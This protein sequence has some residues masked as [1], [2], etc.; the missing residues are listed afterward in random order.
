MERFTPSPQSKRQEADLIR[1]T[2]FFHAID[3]RASNVT[4]KD[5]YEAEN[6]SPGTGKV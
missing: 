6:V 5:V 3:N 2:C 4:I 1:E